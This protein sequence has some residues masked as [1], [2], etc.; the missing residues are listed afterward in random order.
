MKVNNIDLVE[1]GFRVKDFNIS[2]P[3]VKN[4]SVNIPLANGGIVSNPLRRVLFDTRKIDLILDAKL[5]QAGEAYTKFSKLGEYLFS[6]PK[7]EITFE[8]DK[9]FFW[10]GRCTNVDIKRTYDKYVE[11]EIQFEVEPYKYDIQVAGEPWLWNPFSFLNGIIASKPQTIL[12]EGQFYIVNRLQP[13]NPTIESTQQCKVVFEDVEYNIQIG[14]NYF[15]SLILK[16]GKNLI[17]VIG[18][19]TITFKYRMGEL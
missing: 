15:E 12:T 16:Q 7:Y 17:K 10:L 19:T 6:K 9:N 13:V 4:P 5:T 8:W 11:Y 3:T 2:P 1:K 18:D 14:S